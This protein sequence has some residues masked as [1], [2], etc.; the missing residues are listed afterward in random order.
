[1]QV[2]SPILL[3]L[4]RALE[5]KNC[6][7]WHPARLQE[8]EE[9]IVERDDIDWDWLPPEQRLLRV[10]EVENDLRDNHECEYSRRFQRIERHNRQPLTCELCHARHRIYLL[11][12]RWCYNVD[13]IAFSVEGAQLHHY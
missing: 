12:Y 2:Q 3:S 4:W 7:Q 10:A 11:Q 9:E 8:R 1:M 5:E 13:V 6:V